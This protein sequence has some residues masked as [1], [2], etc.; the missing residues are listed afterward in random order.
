[1][2]YTDGLPTAEIFRRWGAVSTISAA[3]TRRVW[4]ETDVGIAY[5][6]TLIFL[7]GVPS[8]GKGFVIKE[9]E[10][11]LRAI[12]FSVDEN[13]LL[14]T[15]GI[16]MG[17]DSTTNAGIFDECYDERAMKVYDWN[18]QK[19]DFRSLVIV[20]EE[21]STLF[22]TL[23]KAMMGRL[24]K[25]A[26]CNEVVSER[27]RKTGEQQHI[28]RPVM[29]I[30]AGIQP[31]M[32]A[33]IFPDEAWGMGLLARSNFAFAE[34]GT[35]VPPF[36][37][38]TRKSQD[39][40]DKLSADLRTIASLTGPFLYKEEAALFINDWWVNH[41]ERDQPTHPRLSNYASKRIQHL[42]RISMVFSVSR[43]NDLIIETE[44]VENALALMLSTEQDIPGMFDNVLSAQSNDLAMQEIAHQIETKVALTGQ[45]V[46][47]HEVIKMLCKKVSAAAAPSL[48]DQMKAQHLIM[49]VRPTNRLPGEGG[50]RAFIH[51]IRNL[52]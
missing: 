6:N 45:P 24:I 22:S 25:Y 50:L 14:Q 9:A 28:N 42:F 34:K 31:D 47:Y 46:P 18:G 30:L 15:Q 32:M 38:K 41:S 11:L 37:S 43:T 16:R 39:L 44:D 3:L 7:V 26:D 2:E 36:G 52:Q 1:M 23:D 10:A 40:Q 35:K 49:E 5:P 12:D 17:V 21:A 33:S 4:T 13:V 20:A 48:L 51:N 29:S 27:L 19:I 8:T